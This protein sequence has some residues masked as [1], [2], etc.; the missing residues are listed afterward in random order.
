MFDA[1]YVLPALLS[2][3]VLVISLH[4]VAVLIRALVILPYEPPG[5]ALL[6]PHSGLGFSLPSE[7]ALVP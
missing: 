2:P 5:D 4:P 3:T 6:S 1:V 7:F